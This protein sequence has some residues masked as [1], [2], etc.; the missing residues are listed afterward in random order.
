MHRTWT[1]NLAATTAPGLTEPSSA[2]STNGLAVF[3]GSS[4]S[5]HYLVGGTFL[6]RS[7]RT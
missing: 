3:R 7:Y 5:R 1:G 6:P 4:V 2:T